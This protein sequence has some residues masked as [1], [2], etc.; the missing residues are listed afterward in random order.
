MNREKLI[1]HYS[2]QKSRNILELNQ[3]LKLKQDELQNKNRAIS[4]SND[5]LKLLLASDIDISSIEIVTDTIKVITKEAENLKQQISE[6]EQQINQEMMINQEQNNKIELFTKLRDV[7][8][9]A[10]DD[11]RKQI[12]NILI[13]RIVVSN[14]YS[15]KIK[16]YLNY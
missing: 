13:D 16:V 5:K 11:R 8:K 6:L 3:M 10:S 2:S 1:E 7:Y 9:L 14:D 15:Y 12:L 4:K